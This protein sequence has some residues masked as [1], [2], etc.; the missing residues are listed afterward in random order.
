MK[1]D[2]ETHIFRWV[3]IDMEAGL[4]ILE[5]HMLEWKNE[6]PHVDVLSIADEKRM[7]ID[8]ALDCKCEIVVRVQ[9]SDCGCTKGGRMR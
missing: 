5:E 9:Y 1:K 2:I 7:D 4:E 8:K 3:G 6:N